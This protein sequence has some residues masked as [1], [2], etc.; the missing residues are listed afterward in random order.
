MFFNIRRTAFDIHLKSVFFPVEG[1]IST[2]VELNFQV[3][4]AEKAR[5]DGINAV[6]K[7]ELDAEK[8]RA[9]KESYVKAI[10]DRVTEASK[11]ERRA[12][13]DLRDEERNVVYRA[14]IRR[15]MID[16]WNSKPTPEQR[17]VDHVRSEVIRALFDIDAMLY[18][19][20]PEW[21]V[22]RVNRSFQQLSPTPVRIKVTN[23]H[24]V[25]ED[26]EV[27]VT[28]SDPVGWGGLGEAGRD[29]YLITSGSAPARLGSS[30]GWLLQ[31]DGDNLRNAFLNAP[32]VKAVIPIRPGRETAALVWLR[33]IEGH[34]NDGWD[35]PYVTTT[36][37]DAEFA[38]KQEARS[39][40]Y[41]RAA[42]QGKRRY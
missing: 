29:N 13:W 6:R 22:P 14:L 9:I 1:R 38:G 19:V 37:E 4:K 12:S 34:E 42:R 39:S 36:A 20:A 11:I 7:R 17:R 5:I 25:E 26:R 28:F 24:G 33:A 18:F 2:E 15:L 30:L 40:R 41:R 32:W 23:E 27:A 8:I 10:Q 3:T 31:L 35:T 16:S 21:W